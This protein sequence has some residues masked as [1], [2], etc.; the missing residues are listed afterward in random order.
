MR[1]FSRVWGFG[2]SGFGVE[3]STGMA[4]Q[5]SKIDSL[6]QVICRALAVRIR[7]SRL[8]IRVLNPKPYTRFL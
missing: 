1:V 4:V 8:Q 2:A 5:A 6:A 7:A 3:R